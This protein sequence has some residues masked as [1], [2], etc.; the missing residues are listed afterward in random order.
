M[1]DN[2]YGLTKDKVK[3]SKV[4]NGVNEIKVTRDTNLWTIFKPQ[5]TNPITILLLFTVLISFL[6]YLFYPEYNSLAEVFLIIIILL[7]NLSWGFYQ[8]YKI[9]KTL[10]SLQS[11]NVSYTSVIRDGEIQVIDSKEVVVG[12]IIHFKQGE[13]VKADVKLIQA[14][15]LIIDESFLTGE[16][17]PRV[18][19]RS[20]IIHSNTQILNGIGI[21]H[22]IAIGSNTTIGKIADELNEFS[23]HASNLEVKIFK[24][25]KIIASFAVG[26]F[27]FISFIALLKGYYFFESL[28]YAFTLLVAIIPVGLPTILSIVFLIVGRI[29]A[30]QQALVKDVK[31][32]ETLGQVDYVCSDKT[33]TLTENKMSVVSKVISPDYEGFEDLTKLLSNPRSTT[34]KAL[35]DSLDDISI[36]HLTILDEIVFSPERKYN[37]I[38]VYDKKAKQYFVAMLG[39]PEALQPNCDDEFSIVAKKLAM[40]GIRVLVSIFKEIDEN[41]ALKDAI[42]ETDFE[43]IGIY[44]FKDPIKRNMAAT[45]SKMKTAGIKVVMITGDHVDT[46]KHIARELNIFNP[47]KDIAISGEE[48]DNISDDELIKIIHN[49]KVFG[50][51]SPEQK[52]RIVKT[53]Q[54][55]DH[56]VA[57]LGDGTNDAVAIKQADVGIAMGYAG[58]DIAKEAADLIILDDDFSS[59]TNGISSGRILYDNIQK[60]LTHILSANVAYLVSFFIILIMSYDIVLPL[61]PAL[62]L[63]V[64]FISDGLPALSLGF[65]PQEEDVMKRSPLSLNSTDLNRNLVYKVIIRGV[66]LGIIV[67]FGFNYVYSAT[68]SYGIS[69]S[70]AFLLICFSQLFSIYESRVLTKRANFRLRSN[71]RLMLSMWFVL[72]LDLLIVFSPINEYFRLEV[73]PVEYLLMLVLLSLI[74]T[75]VV[76]ILKPICTPHVIK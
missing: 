76:I 21:G 27:L 31:L 37:A 64:N 5:L 55:K 52:L 70:F 20:D 59:V 66:V 63:W 44:G 48:L 32:L 23:R 4:E 74:P 19:S 17:E 46:A 69:S 26:A 40:D 61:T 67:A 72:I 9:Q 14:K 58:T 65:E 3:K 13:I 42:S 62:V 28:E 68:E 22:V 1:L 18:A 50:R 29:S 51:M 12:D 47:K 24:I 54:A 33:G 71:I 38:K 36:E 2:Y 35:F 10:K 25:S 73:I 75:L 7:I 43:L 41:C 6:S 45:I 39:A 15:D 30:K 34:S 16:S 49:I 57:M 56:K 8:E 60:F 53:I 11:L